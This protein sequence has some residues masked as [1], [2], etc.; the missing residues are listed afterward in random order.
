MTK[1]TLNIIE[2]SRRATLAWKTGQYRKLKREAVRAMRRDKEAQVHG[3]CETAE[4][5][6]WSTDFRPAYSGIQTLR[7]SM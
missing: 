2:E 4:S 7:F 5:H 3:V 6:L 1:E